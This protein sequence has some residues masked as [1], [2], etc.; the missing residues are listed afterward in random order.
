MK[1][2]RALF[3]F[4]LLF[5]SSACSSTQE[6]DSTE[7]LSPIKPIEFYGNTQGTTFAVLCNDNIEISIEE[8]EDVLHN[9]DLAL[10]SYIPNSTLTHLNEAAAGEFNY[11]DEFGYFNRCY[12]LSTEIYE[13]TDGDFDPTVYP[14]V[15]GWGFM[16]DIEN[17]PDSATVDSLRALLGFQKG[18]HFTFLNEVPKTDT[19]SEYLIVKNTPGAKLDFNAVAQGLAVDV[20]AELLTSKGAKNYFV[21]IGGEIR[22][23]G[24]NKEGELWRIG[25]DKPIED[26][27][28]EDREIQDIVNLDNRSIAT[29]G[30]YRRYYEKDGIK[31]SHTLDPK[32]GYPVTHSLLSATVIA[33]SCG[34]A[35]ALATAF[36]VKGT[37]ES[38]NFLKGHRDLDIEVYLIFTNNKG[39]IETFYTKG[40]KR[41]IQ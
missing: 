25:I 37:D 16:K 29:S 28:V 40:F 9:F 5:I 21:E 19:I 31:Y 33:N 13:L 34:Y 4:L 39:R 10:S 8:I 22:V 41:M 14:L 17:V 2:N 7:T 18:F 12:D 3:Y 11:E 6:E 30:S 20:L 24:R 35:D 38:I 23:K 15:D 27:S 1:H 26:S 36:M 32:T